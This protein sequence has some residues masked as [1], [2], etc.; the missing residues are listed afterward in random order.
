[1]AGLLELKDV[2]VRKAKE[3]L[4]TSGIITA[5]EAF[6]LGMVN[7]VVARDELTSFTMALATVTACEAAPT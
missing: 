2:G 4:F 5:D 3:M 6:R 7:H 1:M